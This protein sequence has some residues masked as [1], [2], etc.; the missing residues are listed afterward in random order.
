MC[1]S[2]ENC[3]FYIEIY[4]Q[5]A[6]K[7]PGIQYIL[8]TLFFTISH[9]Q[10]LLI[11]ITVAA[12]P[13]KMKTATGRNIQIWYEHKRKETSQEERIEKEKIKLI[14]HKE[15]ITQPNLQCVDNIVF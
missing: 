5:T 10:I 6:K 3:G 4:A 12:T 14:P 11:I 1:E 13:T 9:E 15:Y 7:T 8:S 2:A